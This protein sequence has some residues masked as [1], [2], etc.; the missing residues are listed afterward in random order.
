MKE[1]NMIPAEVIFEGWRTLT[2]ENK[3]VGVSLQTFQTIVEWAEKNHTAV[4]KGEDLFKGVS[5]FKTESKIRRLAA[6]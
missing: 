3:I 1:S 2:A 6:K 5:S 4:V